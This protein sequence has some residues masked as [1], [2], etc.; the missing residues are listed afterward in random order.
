ML[1][2]LRFLFIGFILLTILSPVNAY[3]VS[4]EPF[5]ELE[6][7]T[8]TNAKR[9]IELFVLTDPDVRMNEIA[10]DPTMPLLG[11]ISDQHL[12]LWD[13][14]EQTY[15]WQVELERPQSGYNLAFNAEGTQLVAGIDSRLYLWNIEDSTPE[16]QFRYPS[17]LR[18]DDLVTLSDVRFNSSSSEI[19][20]AQRMGGVSR[21]AVNNGELLFNHPFDDFGY[22][23]NDSVGGS[24][25]S[26]DG[27][28]NIMTGATTEIVEI[29]DTRRGII[30]NRVRLDDFIEVVD[31]SG[32]IVYPLT[33]DN[34]NEIVLLSV[35][36][37]RRG[38]APDQI[39]WLSV[40][41]DIVHQVEHNYSYMWAGQFSPDEQILALGNRENGD[42]YLW[43]AN[44][45]DE[46]VTLMGHTQTITS[47]A[48]NPDGT[49]LVSASTDGTVRL[50]G[51]P[52]GE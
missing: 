14:Q 39:V 2:Q 40:A 45:G 37:R 25:L 42:I 5:P 18:G 44:T 19:I 13:L 38:I 7:I 29:R 51:V 12:A 24:I 48:F 16:K 4:T 50:W 3:Q 21:W 33:I 15:R 1:K 22:D 10:F 8:L 26:V 49:L 23:S 31:D 32:F 41:G 20:I 30:L 43:D 47:L 6:T 36:F 27:R 17:N 46:I 35:G 52:A 34:D 28:I 11:Y 9:V